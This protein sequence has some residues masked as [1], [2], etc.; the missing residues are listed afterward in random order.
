MLKD[1]TLGQ[2]FPG[3]TPA[4]RL[5]PRTKIVL[6]VLYIEALFHA[7]NLL[8]YAQVAVTFVT[9]ARV[10]KVGARALL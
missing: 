9:C 10:S 5:D 1:I 4:H 8:S 3:D 7:K 2:Y 6:V